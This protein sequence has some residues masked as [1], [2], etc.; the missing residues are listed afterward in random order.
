MDISTINWL[1]VFAAALSTFIIGA[2]WYGPIFGKPWMAEHG[3]TEEQLKSS[4]MGKIFGL[5]FVLEFIMALNLAIFL[6]DSSDVLWGVAAGF[7][8]GFGWIALAMGVNA[9]FSRYSLR[10]WFID[11]FYFV[12][13]FMLMGGI[14]TL[15]K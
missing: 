4:N 2:L 1:A 6:S 9:L 15:W 11:S 3:F 13:T 7:L 10:L 12:V 14:L 8:A 5:A